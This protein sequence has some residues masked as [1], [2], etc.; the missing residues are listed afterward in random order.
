MARTQS[1]LVDHLVT[2][3]VVRS[4][5]VATAMRQVD[6]ALFINPSEAPLRA[7]YEDHPLPIGCG[8]T[9]SAPHMH[10]TCLE[11]LEGH[12]VP[13]AR[14]LDVGS[15]SGYLTAAMALLVHPGGRVLGIEKFPELAKRSVDAVR[16]AVPS[17]ARPPSPPASSPHASLHPPTQPAWETPLPAAATSV[18]K[19]DSM[20]AMPQSAL[21]TPQTPE[22]AERQ[23]AA[24]L[25]AAH[26]QKAPTES[27]WAPW[28]A[29]RPRG[30]PAAATL[31]GEGA[32]WSVVH[33]N[34]LTDTLAH[35]APFN[36]I[37]VGAAAD[38][39]P[40]ELLAV[41][42]KGGRMVIP[43][44]ARWQSQELMVVDRDAD[45]KLTSYSTMGV[46]YVPLTRPT[47]MED[48]F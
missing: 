36:A 3:G 39:V 21:P 46:T 28:S 38:D 19:G 22:Q 40:D 24:R 7:A 35:E 25:A 2:R 42:A 15:G 44:G 31:L 11:L 6:R 29:W 10:G 5:R 34:A 14:A 33:G 47:E 41:L 1:D 18:C 12:L 45:G 37:H 26:T 32:N 16:T 43:V 23:R 30:G 8:Q 17:L 13:G 9:V 4:P 48:G 27:R 20:G